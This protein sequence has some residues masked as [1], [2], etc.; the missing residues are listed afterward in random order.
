MPQLR[1]KRALPATFL[2]L[3]VVLGGCTQMAP[4]SSRLLAGDGAQASCP[5][6]AGLRQEF[7]AEVDPA[8]P[9][10]RLLSGALRRLVNGERCRRGLAPLGLSQPAVR[11]AAGQAGTM[12]RYNMM[13]HTSPLPGRE[14]LER[15]L[16][17]EQ[18]ARYRLAAEN[19]ARSAA[20]S[21]GQREGVCLGRSATP[22]A[23]YA[24]LA[25]GLFGMWI[26]SEKHRRNIL[27]PRFR[28]VGSGIAVNPEKYSCGEVT[29]AMVF[30]G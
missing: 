25:E 18:I 27:E 13:S 9:N 15:R 26:Q 24:E 6:G 22:D 30:L 23:T 16:A 11:A 14:T 7:Q 20:A 8:D 17:A 28:A 4:S 21:L 2:A 29:A 10:Q 19:I 12:A 3:A 1:S 5:A